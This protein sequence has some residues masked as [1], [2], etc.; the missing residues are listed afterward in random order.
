MIVLICRIFKKGTD[1]LIYKTELVLWI[2]ENKLMVTWGERGG[3]INW[4]IEIDI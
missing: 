1:K 2:I 3:G 4:E